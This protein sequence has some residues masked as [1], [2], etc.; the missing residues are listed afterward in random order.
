MSPRCSRWGHSTW[1]QQVATP[2][3]MGQWESPRCRRLGRL[4]WAVGGWDQKMRGSC[5]GLP[6]FTNSRVRAPCPAPHATIGT[7][8]AS[9]IYAGCATRGPSALPGPRQGARSAPGRVA[10]RARTARCLATREAKDPKAFRSMDQ[11]NARSGAE[12]APANWGRILGSSHTGV[13]AYSPSIPPIAPPRAGHIMP[14]L[15]GRPHC[16]CCGRAPVERCGGGI[17]R[18]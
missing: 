18:G 9:L 16:C 3:S 7:A 5:P 8:M 13:I 4:G 15:R 14:G 17:R 10:R 11:V 12:E 6:G 2:P 1:Q